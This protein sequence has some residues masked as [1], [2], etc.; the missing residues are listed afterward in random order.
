VNHARQ[1]IE[2][3]NS[4]LSK[5]PKIERDH[6]HTFLGLAARLYSKLA[7]HT[8]CIYLNRLLGHSDFLCVKRLAFPI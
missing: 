4:R 2:V 1:I 8:F 7:A 6:A 3:V 5:Q